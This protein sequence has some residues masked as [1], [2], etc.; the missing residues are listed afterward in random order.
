MIVATYHP[1]MFN[2]FKECI[3]SLQNQSYDDLE[4][5]CIVDG[6]ENYYK[7]IKEEIPDIEIHLNEKN[8]G[9]LLS[10]NRGA[11]L[12]EGD[13]IAF[14]DDDAVADRKWIEELV[15]T[16]EL[17]AIAAGGKLVP[18]WITKEPKWFPEEFYWMIGA[19]HLGFPDKIAEVRNTFG[20][21]IS[22]RRDIFLELGGFN[23]SMGGIKGNRM[24]QGGE[25]EFCERMR[26]RYGKGVM[27]NPDAI[28]YHKI[29][30]RRLEKKFLL[31]RA[32]WQGYSKAVMK[33][34]AG[35]IGEEM[36][37]I[38][39]LMK[40]RLVVRF[41]DMLKGSGEDAV[42]ILMILIFTFFV[43]VGYIWGLLNSN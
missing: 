38:K 37:F 19:T 41:V 29:F 6:D 39:F 27:Y 35:E 4:I 11:K 13:I 33:R 17:D 31:R 16:Y 22:F 7:M 8:L 9:L 14:I 24:L 26:Q 21:N 32:F 15:K 10:R 23:P 1:N 40:D 25:T 36:T 3:D 5:I 20:S 42:K 43:G 30:S 18:L 2:H 28:V 34:M 12:A